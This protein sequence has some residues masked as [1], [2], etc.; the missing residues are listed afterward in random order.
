[1]TAL[2]RYVSEEYLAEITAHVQH[3][4]AWL[5]DRPDLVTGTNGLPDPA[6]R[7][8]GRVEFIWRAMPI[9]TNVMPYRFWLMQRLH[10]AVAQQDSTGQAAVRA[11]L[12]ESGLDSLLDLRT[13]RR[14]ERVNH[15][16][17]W[18]PVASGA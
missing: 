12:T 4:N 16:E 7:G 10:D 14:V 18:G 2:M 17:V 8:I 15:L 13:T 11:T 9:S 3:A 5:G 6:S 1:L